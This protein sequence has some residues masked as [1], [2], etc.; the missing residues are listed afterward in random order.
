MTICARCFGSTIGHIAS[1]VLFFLGYLPSIPI[2]LVLVAIMFLDW[3]LQAFAHI[4]STNFRRVVTGFV[5]GFGIGTI[6]WTVLGLVITYLLHP[7]Q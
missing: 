3:S 4:P 2:A 7:L 5:G 6:I 1:V